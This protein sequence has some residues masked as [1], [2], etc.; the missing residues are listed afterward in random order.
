M[1]FMSHLLCVLFLT[2]L[3]GHL[4]FGKFKDDAVRLLSRSFY[5]DG[6][7]GSDR[8]IPN[9]PRVQGCSSENMVFSG[10]SFFRVLQ[11]RANQFGPDAF[12]MFA[13]TR[14]VLVSNAG[15]RCSRSVKQGDG[16]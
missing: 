10:R 14:L 3:R 13:A 15:S 2:G 12:C 16:R 1:N 6:A 8:A 9:A 11:F 7:N 4:D 5:E